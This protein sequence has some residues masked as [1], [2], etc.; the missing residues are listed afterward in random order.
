MLLR[1][2]DDD[3]LAFITGLRTNHASNRRHDAVEYLLGKFTRRAEAQ[4]VILAIGDRPRPVGS[5]T[6]WDVL[7]VESDLQARTGF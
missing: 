1:S 5:I 7:R 6:A 4:L 2:I 3:D